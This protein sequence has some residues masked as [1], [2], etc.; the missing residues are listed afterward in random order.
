MLEVKKP[1]TSRAGYLARRLLPIMVFTTVA[2]IPV[3]QAQSLLDRIAWCESRGLQHRHG[4]VLVNSSGHVGVLQ[5]SQEYVRKAR[6]EG[7]NLYKEA[8]NLRYGAKVLREKG[9]RDWNASRACWQA[10]ARD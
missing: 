7:Y 6:K 2:M 4:S 9:P 8:D 5:F 1:R 3:A 10:W